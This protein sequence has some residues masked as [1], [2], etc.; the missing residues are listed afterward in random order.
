MREM[1][2][3]A[4]LE[5]PLFESLRS[6][7]AFVARYYFQHFLSEEAVQ[8]L[9]RFRDLHL[10]GEE[11]RALVAVREQG[12]IDNAMYRGLNRVDTLSASQA[13]RRLRDAGLLEQ[14]GRG[15]GTYYQ[16]TPWLLGS[17]E[18]ADLSSDPEGLSSNLPALSRN[19]EAL[20]SNPHWAALPKDLREQVVSLGRRAPPAAMQ[21]AII[22]LCRHQPWQASELAALL[23]RTPDYVATQHLRPLV[24]AGV[25]AYTRPDQPNHPHQAYRATEGGESTA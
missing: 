12:A 16:T 5:P 8:W 21:A 14:K 13:L 19:L 18:E 6:N 10:S 7:D 2:V 22:A 9:S 20:T 3:D 4:G 25:L 23:G 24:Q 1:M 17:D 15:S 11:A